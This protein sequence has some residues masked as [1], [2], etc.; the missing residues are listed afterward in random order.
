MKSNPTD[1][2]IIQK[3]RIEEKIKLILS[4]KAV[5]EDLKTNRPKLALHIYSQMCYLLADFVK[6]ESKEKEKTQ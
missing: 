2:Q 4:Y 1:I 3:I 5:F 6:T